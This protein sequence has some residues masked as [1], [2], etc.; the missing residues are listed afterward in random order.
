MSALAADL[1]VVL[2]LCFVIF[3]VF[4]GFLTWQMPRV[5]W[6]HLPAVAWGALVEFNQWICPLT[7]LEQQLRARAGE[8]GYNESFVEHYLMPLLYPPGLTPAMQWV[9]GALVVAANILIYGALLWR[10]KHV[11]E[12][13]C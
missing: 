9:L 5:A 10:M 6:V 3:V 12:G 2:H 7:P 1:L 11:R 4:G 13:G 8:S